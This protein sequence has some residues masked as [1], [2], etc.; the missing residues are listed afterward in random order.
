M[1]CF[2]RRTFHDSTLFLFISLK[3]PE[4]AVGDQV[5]PILQTTDFVYAIRW[6]KEMGERVESTPVDILHNV[7][8]FRLSSF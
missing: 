6:L 2:P 3:F 7:E 4:R 8:R 1:K 5:Q